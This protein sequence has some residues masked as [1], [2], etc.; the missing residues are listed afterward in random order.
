MDK[1]IS[2]LYQT[3]DSSEKKVANRLIKVLATGDLDTKKLKSI[4]R[5]IGRKDPSQKKRKSGYITYYSSEYPLVKAS[6]PDLNLGGVAKIIGAKWQALDQEDRD[7]FKK[8]AAAGG[9]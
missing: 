3:L 2:N 1:Q 9:V 6:N 8:K 5:A 4:N 7:A